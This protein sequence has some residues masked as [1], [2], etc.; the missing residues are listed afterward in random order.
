MR[1]FGADVFLLRSGTVRTRGPWRSMLSIPP[2]NGLIRSEGVYPRAGAQVPRKPRRILT[3]RYSLARFVVAFVPFTFVLPVSGVENV[4]HVL[5]PGLGGVELIRQYESSSGPLEDAL[6]DAS[7]VIR[8]GTAV[9][10]HRTLI[11]AIYTTTS[12]SAP[13]TSLCAGTY[14]NPPME[15]ELIPLEGSGSPDW[16]Y[17]G[18]EFD[19]AASHDGEVVVAT[20]FDDATTV[21]VHKWHADSG[22]PE[23]S[24]PISPATPGSHRSVLVSR[25]GSTIAVLVTMQDAPQRARLYY[26]EASSATPAGFIDGADGSFGRNLAITEHGEYMAFIAGA[27]AYVVER[28]TDTVRWSGSM[29]ASNDALAL[30]GDAHYLAFGWSS[31]QMREWNGLTYSLLWADAVSGSRLRSCGFSSDG[32]VFVSGWYRNDFLQ[33][34]VQL[35]E[36][37]SPTEHWA[38]VYPAA[39]GSYQDVPHDVAITAD[40][41]LLAVGSWGDQLNT[42]AEVHVFTRD[43]PLPILTVDAPGSVFDIDIATTAA[44]TFVAACGKHIH[45]NQSGRGGD[46]LSI[47][48]DDP[49]G[50]GTPGR[51]LATSSL[52]VYPNPFNP[53]TTMSYSLGRRYNMLEFTR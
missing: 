44:G 6:T 13:D 17:A 19:V 45:A 46:L 25:D 40:G 30:S 43:S 10:W 24:F 38:Y 2:R 32:S 11:D 52:E 3:L 8:Q 18:N 12:I 48:L 51:G 36:M 23:W 53:R 34:R 16:V 15:T 50:V 29:G 9:V 37:P 35:H 33:N 22:V 28:D 39:G 27:D 7:P 1:A 5:H 47:R 41:G 4:R 49:V 26:F 31:L 20:D 14:L 21:T 42:N